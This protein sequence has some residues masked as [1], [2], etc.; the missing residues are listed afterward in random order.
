MTHALGGRDCDHVVLPGKAQLLCPAARWQGGGRW[1]GGTETGRETGRVTGRVTGREKGR[2]TGRVTA[3]GRR[4]EG[5]AG[6]GL[7]RIIHG[8]QPDERTNC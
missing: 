6:E 4:L 3:G 2:V 8:L 7:D 1:E 5:R